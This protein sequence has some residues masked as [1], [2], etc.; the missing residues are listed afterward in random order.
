MKKI[1]N[2]LLVMVI[3]ILYLL[4]IGNYII[5]NNLYSTISSRFTAKRI[6]SNIITTIYNKNPNIPID[7]LS[8]LQNKIEKSKYMDSISKKYIDA[9][10][11]DIK[12]LKPGKVNIDYELDELIYSLDNDFSKLELIKIRQE[13][14]N[15][16][17]NSIYEYSFNNLI[18]NNNSLIKFI[19]NIYN[20]TSSYTYLF[21][22]LLIILL[23]ILFIINIKQ[24]LKIFGITFGTLGIVSFIF[25]V[26]ER[27]V[28]EKKLAVLLN[29]SS[30]LINI[31][32][33]YIL[34]PIFIILSLLLL[35]FYRKT[36]E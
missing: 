28:L 12:V 34:M 35:F 33:F 31:N 36:Q 25:M 21:Y 19:L 13:L 11:R 14:D 3:S 8:D 22:I 27:Q 10:V 24:K 29:E 17:I 15:S 32:I 9:M 26:I 18:S 23:I 5:N 2:I 4:I 1:I 16:D 6:S 30:I 7:K 20:L